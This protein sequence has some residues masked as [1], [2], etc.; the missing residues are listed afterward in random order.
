MKL[1]DSDHD[2][3]IPGC[4]L[5]VYPAVDKAKFHAFFSVRLKNTIIINRRI[6]EPGSF[7]HDRELVF[8]MTSRGMSHRKA[9]MSHYRITFTLP[10]PVNHI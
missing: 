8:G 6:G 10:D 1:S 5:K 3:L 4:F 7:F 9:R 2:C